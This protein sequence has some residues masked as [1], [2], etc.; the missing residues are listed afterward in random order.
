MSS[1]LLGCLWYRLYKLFPL[2]FQMIWLDTS[3]RIHAIFYGNEFFKRAEVDLVKE[4]ARDILID[5]RK[6]NVNFWST[7]LPYGLKKEKN[8]SYSLYMD[9]IIS[10]KIHPSYIDENEIDISL[11]N[12]QIWK[13]IAL[14]N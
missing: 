11:Q 3:F 13:I 2:R 8:F 9:Y 4:H 7:F 6:R 10:L 1:K 14:P 5:N 12:E